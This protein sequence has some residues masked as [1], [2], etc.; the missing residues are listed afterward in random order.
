M[1]RKNLLCALL[2]ALLLCLLPAAALATDI[3]VIFDRYE[4]AAAKKNKNFLPNHVAQS[5]FPRYL[6]IEG[7]IY[8]KMIF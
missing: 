3:P 1:F 2:A 4:I 5:T 7:E 8:P 6:H